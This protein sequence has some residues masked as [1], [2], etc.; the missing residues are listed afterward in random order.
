MATIQATVSQTGQ[1]TAS[2]TFTLADAD[3]DKAIAAYQK[4][5]DNVFGAP[6]TRNQVLSVMFDRLIKT[7]IQDAVRN[8][9]TVPKTVPPPIDIT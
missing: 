6:A 3:M 9:E 2:K 1:S 5:G 7:A 4:L 8:N